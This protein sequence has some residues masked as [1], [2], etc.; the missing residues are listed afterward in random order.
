MRCGESDIYMYT[1]NCTTHHIPHSTTTAPVVGARWFERIHWCTTMHAFQ[2]CGR[3]QA[4]KSLM[5]R[6]HTKRAPFRVVLTIHAID[7][8]TLVCLEHY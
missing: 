3:R 7:R 1:L 4:I 8:A 5:E 2:L 6:T